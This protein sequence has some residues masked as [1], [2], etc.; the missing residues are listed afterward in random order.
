MTHMSDEDIHITLLKSLYIISPEDC[1]GWY[2]HCGYIWVE[3]T[4]YSLPWFVPL[5]HW[6]LCLGS[7]DV[8]LSFQLFLKHNVVTA[9]IVIT[10]LFKSGFPCKEIL[11][12]AS[13]DWSC[14]NIIRWPARQVVKTQISTNRVLPC[15]CQTLPSKSHLQSKLKKLL[16]SF[17]SLLSA[18][19]PT[20]IEE[21]HLEYGT[22]IGYVAGFFFIWQSVSNVEVW[23]KLLPTIKVTG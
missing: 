13:K 3:S 11:S 22:A 7:C 2:R 1:Y 6:L 12:I 20:R 9:I 16:Y 17:Y 14:Y 21:T 19:H 10:M 23:L 15:A 4:L 18:S 5:H 8:P